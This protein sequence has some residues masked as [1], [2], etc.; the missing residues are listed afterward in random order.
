M[1]KAALIALLT[2]A[3]GHGWAT[4]PPMHSPGYMQTTWATVHGTAD[5]AD[6]VAKV[7]L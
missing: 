6:R 1:H 5:N 7:A 2:L 4:E 3:T